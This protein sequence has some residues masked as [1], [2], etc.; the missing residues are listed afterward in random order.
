MANVLLKSRW[1]GIAD[2]DRIGDGTLNA[3]GDDAQPRS[4]LGRGWGWC[5]HCHCGA[6]FGDGVRSQ[7]FEK[8]DT[9]SAAAR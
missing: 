1:R 8:S 5:R 4:G 6:A 7:A 3:A 9:R 2:G